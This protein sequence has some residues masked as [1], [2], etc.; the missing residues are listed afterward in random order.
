MDNSAIK[1]ATAPLPTRKTLK[2]R[3]NI[4]FQIVRF[5]VF[6]IRMLKMVTRAHR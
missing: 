5:A 1:I 2:S 6:N 4:P 3:K